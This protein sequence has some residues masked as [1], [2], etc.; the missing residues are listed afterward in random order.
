MTLEETSCQRDCIAYV[1]DKVALADKREM[2]VFVILVEE[3]IAGLLIVKNINWRIPKCELAYFIDRTHE[4]QSVMSVALD[5]L[6]EHCFNTL[7]MHKIYI[8]VSP[9]N[10]RSRRLPIKKGFKLEGLLRHEFRIETGEL[11]DVEYY[12]KI[13]G[14]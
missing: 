1:E 3:K 14:E 4:G 8:C 5:M 10:E 12:G 9:E 13:K 11:V 6:L 7:K 2:F